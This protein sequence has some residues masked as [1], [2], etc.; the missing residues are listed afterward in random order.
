MIFRTHN[1][2]LVH[3]G[4]CIMRR[5]A[6]ACSARRH[7]LYR[8][9]FA[10][11]GV[12]DDALQH[13]F[14]LFT[15]TPGTTGD[16]GVSW[17]KRSAERKSAENSAPSTSVTPPASHPES[18]DLSPAFAC[19]QDPRAAAM[20]FRQLLF[21]RSFRLVVSR[22]IREMGTPGNSGARSVQAVRCPAP[23]AP[24]AWNRRRALARHRAL[25]VTVV[26]AQMLLA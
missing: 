2:W 26:T 8:A 6:S 23:P 25:A 15:R 5:S 22:S 1:T 13:H 10:I 14:A 24:G 9:T 11:A 12:L 18:G 17:A 7:S 3:G 4:S 16:L 19:H 20:H 21:Q